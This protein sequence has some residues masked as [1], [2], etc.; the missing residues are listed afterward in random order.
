MALASDSLS[1]L[2]WVCLAL[3]RDQGQVEKITCGEFAMDLFVRRGIA[4][5]YLHSPD[6]EFLFTRVLLGWQGGIRKAL[7]I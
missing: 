4:E 5:Q 7:G 2:V 6:L 3:E 1:C